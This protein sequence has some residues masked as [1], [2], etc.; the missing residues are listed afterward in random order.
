MVAYVACVYYF[1][2]RFVRG[3]LELNYVDMGN[4]SWKHHVTFA[5][6]FAL[7]SLLIRKFATHLPVPFAGVLAQPWSYES[8]IWVGLVSG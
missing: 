8:G 2:A 5:I 7:L 1:V 3:I 4:P 6:S